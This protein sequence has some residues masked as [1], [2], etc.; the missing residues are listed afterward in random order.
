MTEKLTSSLQES[1][2]TL[3]AVSDKEGAV[4]TGLVKAEHFDD[5]YRDIATRI[6][7][8][9]K[10]HGKAPGK[11][12][13]DDVL[14]DILDK[15]DHRKYKQYVRVLE[16]IIN[17]SDSL[18]AK[19]VLSRVNEFVDRQ[20]LKTAL[21]T[22]GELYQSGGQHV[23]K[24]VRAII[25]KA[26]RPPQEGMLSGSFLNDPVK[27]LA[28]LEKN[29]AAY[30]TGIADFD[31]RGLGP[32]PGKMLTLLGSKGSGKSWWC[33]DLGKR[34]MLQRAKVV[35]ITLEMSEEEVIM[36]Y[37][38]S[39]FAISKR[40]E[41]YS[42]TQF[43][44]DKL[45][46]LAG[47]S[48]T[49]HMPRM[50]LESPRIHRYLTRK[51]RKWGIRLGNL[52]V[53]EFPMKSLSVAG[54][55]SY[56]DYLELVHKFVPNVLIIDYPDLMWL[57]GK[58]LRVSIGWTYEMIHGLLQRRNIAG[59]MPTQTSKKGWDAQ[60]VK[61]SMVAEDASKFR[62]AEMVLIYSRT[63]MEKSRGLARLYVDKNRG[64]VDDY[65]VVIS[66]SYATGQFVLNSAYLPSNYQE[67][68]GV[69][70]EEAEE[71]EDGE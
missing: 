43:E 64:D 20:A 45:N 66:Q 29:N 68:L 7:T 8:F 47:M 11:A 62:T 27:A 51:I 12:H 44:F 61:A 35:H 15:P 65:T 60:T 40:R 37:W 48:K 50:N 13:L 41:K 56:L 31:K 55:E 57:D 28:F 59:I 39:F 5:I 33:T 4:A 3:L 53:R 34:C 22:A 42:V 71:D 58:D 67:L 54:L 63:P 14:D 23:N 1:V 52:V 36:R 24:E 38:Q 9:R 17:Q 70:E 21:I 32:T 6:L 25:Q 16:G 26:I 2:L 30:S 18:N 46:R 49:R 10:T 69:S 19:Y